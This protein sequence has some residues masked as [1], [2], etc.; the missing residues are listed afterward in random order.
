M[1]SVAPPPSR[2]VLLV[3]D[4]PDSRETLQLLLTLW[5]YI[6]E[7]AADGLAGVR[8]ALA[9]KPDVAIVDIG[10]PELSGY[11]VAQQVRAV[12]H[13]Q[14]FL[15]ALTGYSKPDDRRQALEA[16]FDVHMPKPADFD[17]LSDLLKR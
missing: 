15:I 2:R 5:G 13:E 7:V 3:E 12:L 17:L 4:N 11:E 9:W 16:G 6:V 14:T 1:P 8:K 10:L